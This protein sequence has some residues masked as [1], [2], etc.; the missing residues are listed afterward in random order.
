MSCMESLAVVSCRTHDSSYHQEK[1]KTQH[2]NRCAD[3]LLVAKTTR[4]HR[5]QDHLPKGNMVAQVNLSKCS[6]VQGLFF[7]EIC[8]PHLK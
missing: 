1:G 5:L 4:I 6:I 2:T 8:R 3:N 7:D